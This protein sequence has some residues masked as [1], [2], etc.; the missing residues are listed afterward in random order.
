[1]SLNYDTTKVNTIKLT[2]KEGNMSAIT[3]CLIFI[4]MAVGISEITN[5]NYK[6]FF[7]RVR[8]YEKS[9]GNYMNLY[10]DETNETIKYYITLEDIKDFIGL[11]TN[12]STLTKTEFL[13]N[14]LRIVIEH[15][16]RE[17]KNKDKTEYD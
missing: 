7:A 6:D 13:N 14:V 8:V 17:L 2:N 1:M 3:N 11:K 5:K 4:T 16:E 9:C 10:D 15:A 12:A